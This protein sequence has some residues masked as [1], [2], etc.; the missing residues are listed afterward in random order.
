MAQPAGELH[1]DLQEM[2]REIQRKV[3]ERH[4]SGEVEGL[5]IQLP[6]LM[7]VLHARDNAEGKVAA[8]G[9]VNPRSGGLVNSVIQSVKKLVARSLN[10][11]VREQVEF[12]KAVLQCVQAVLDAQNEYNRALVDFSKRVQAEVG[13]VKQLPGRVDDVQAHWEHW[14]QGWEEKQLKSDVHLLRTVSELQAAY[15]HRVT[16]ME[17]NFRESTRLQHAEYGASLDKRG[18]EIDSKAAAAA[19]ETQKQIAAVQESLRADL[20]AFQQQIWKALE[21]QRAEMRQQFERL[22]HDEIRV[23]RQK[24]A[25]IGPAAASPAPEIDIDWLRFADAFRGP[26]EKIREQQQH[27]VE[28]FRGSSPVLDLGCGRGE[29]LDVMREAGIPAAGIDLSAECVTRCRNKGLDA[30]RADLFVVLET[31]G[32]RSLGGVHCAQVVEHMAPADVPRLI[33]LLASKMKSGALVAIETPDPECLAIFATHF[34]IDPTHVRPV[35]ASLLAFYLRENGFTD[36]EIVRLNRAAES[37]PAVAELPDAVEKQFFG[38]MDYVVF[39][40]KL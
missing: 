12:N 30:Q 15:N 6:N 21:A 11:H 32:D 17:A 4:P 27:Y 1:P 22:V 20:Q 33:R 9:S 16:L 5:G 24:L 38:G 39:A 29:F 26:E 3:R 19:A 8:I 34:Y 36:I 2:I 28:R 13:P 23:V 40:R 25:S 37:L 7:A 14:R 31:T 10:W 35:P 18:A